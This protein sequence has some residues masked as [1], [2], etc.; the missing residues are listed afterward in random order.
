MMKQQDVILKAMAK[1]I[2]WMEAA[3]IIGVCDRTMRWREILGSFDAGGS[4]LHRDTRNRDGST[5]TAVW[6]ASITRPVVSVLTVQAFAGNFVLLGVAKESSGGCKEGGGNAEI[7]VPQTV[8]KFALPI[9][10]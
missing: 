2:T 7:S 5:G 4:C 3:E 8:L 9:N 1:K 10:I 6:P